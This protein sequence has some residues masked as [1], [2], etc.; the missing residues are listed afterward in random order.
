[1]QITITKTKLTS[2]V[3]LIALTAVMS[4]TV[5]TVTA[6]ERTQEKRR[7]VIVT[8][9]GAR[10]MTIIVEGNGNVTPPET[11]NIAVPATPINQLMTVAAQENGN[12]FFSVSSAVM[13]FENKVVKGIPFSAESVTEFTQSLPDGNR[14]QRKSATGL[15]RDS[16]GR[17]RREFSPP[18]VGMIPGG[19]DPGKSIQ[20]FDP[21]GNTL[22]TLNPS[23]QTVHKVTIPEGLPNF[24]PAAPGNGNVMRF[25]RQASGS[26]RPEVLTLINGEMQKK[27]IRQENLGTQSIDGVTAEGTRTIETIPAGDIGNDRPIE[28]INERWYSGELQMTVLTRHS[29]PRFGDNVWRLTNVVRQEPYAG[30]FQVP[31]D[32]KVEGPGNMQRH[33]ETRVIRQERERN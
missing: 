6:Q 33:I 17:T 13:P 20:I 9:E 7:E 2:A 30:L 5:D 24:G 4:M 3:T 16:E 23:S 27:N 26:G 31:A 11:F 28:I 21:V 1:M 18:V 8:R 10:E 14:I 32:Y 12:V 29:D 19:P 15:H 25:N 22:Y